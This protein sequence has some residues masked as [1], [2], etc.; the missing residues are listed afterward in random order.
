LSQAS[1]VLLNELG[2]TEL[3]R[4]VM[5]NYFEEE[6]PAG[7]DMGRRFSFRDPKQVGRR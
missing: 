3:R 4:D 6:A 7:L 1:T 5:E 2:T